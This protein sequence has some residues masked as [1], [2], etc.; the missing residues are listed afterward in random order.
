MRGKERAIR[1]FEQLLCFGI[2]DGFDLFFVEEVFLYAAMAVDLEAVLVKG[3]LVFSIADVVD[4]DVERLSRPLVRLGLCDV[5]RLWL[6]PIARVFVVIQLGRHIVGSTRWDGGGYLGLGLQW[7]EGSGVAMGLLDISG[8]HVQ[9]RWCLDSHNMV[10]MLYRSDT[11][12]IY[13]ARIGV[14]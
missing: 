10:G 7:L 6:T 12:E 5:R 11:L 1:V 9:K 8:R 14:I 4:D 13:T 3:V 2:V